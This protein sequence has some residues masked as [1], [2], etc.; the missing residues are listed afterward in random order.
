MSKK[1]RNLLVIVPLILVGVGIAAY[2]LLRSR[3]SDTIEVPLGVEEAVII[4][5]SGAPIEPRCSVGEPRG[6]KLVLHSTTQVPHIA[7]F[8]LSGIL[9]MPEDKLRVIA[10]DVGGGFGAKLQVYQE[11]A[12]VLATLDPIGAMSV[13]SSGCAPSASRS[14]PR[15]SRRRRQT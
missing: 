4:T 6:E 15:R 2:F 12:L 5:Y 11:E 13:R 7:R 14:K 1:K 3:P 10:P 9:G 8:V